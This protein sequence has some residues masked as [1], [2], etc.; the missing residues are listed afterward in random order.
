M[1]RSPPETARKRPEAGPQRDAGDTSP[2]G[3]G[4]RG[5]AAQ[6]SRIALSGFL[7]YILQ[8]Q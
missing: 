3:D 6:R 1:C 7:D 2:R 8:Q 4:A 5:G